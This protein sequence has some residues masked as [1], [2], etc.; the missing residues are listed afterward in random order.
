MWL[1][2]VIFLLAIASTEWA[3]LAQTKSF[4]LPVSIIIASLLL[5]FDLFLYIPLLLLLSIL[6]VL[7]FQEP[8]RIGSVIWM[9]AGIVW[10]SIPAFLLYKIRIEFGFLMLISLLV[11]TWIQDTFALYFG[12]WF[13]GSTQFAPGLSPNKTWEGF[14]GGL[15]G[16]I[17]TFTVSG[18]YFSWP[19][20]G[21]LSVGLILGFVGQI[22]DLSISALKRRINLDDTGVVFPGHGGILDRVDALIFNI[23]VF[24]PLCQLMEFLTV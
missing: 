19:L 21:S 11:G 15:A 18:S 2:F 10:L 9:A 4:F 1:G 22:G 14:S 13:G 5:V 8:D 24:Y 3:S 20:W 17:L 23:S 16:M 12:R 7:Y 6:P